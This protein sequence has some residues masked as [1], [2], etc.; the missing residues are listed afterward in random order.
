MVSD[1]NHI[2]HAVIESHRFMVLSPNLII[3]S[4]SPRSIQLLERPDRYA[5]YRCDRNQYARRVQ[6]VAL[7][8]VVPTGMQYYYFEG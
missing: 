5:K 7:I 4:H 3:Y 1:S 2:P 8:S 6:V